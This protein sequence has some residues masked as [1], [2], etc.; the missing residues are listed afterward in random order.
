MQIKNNL[1]HTKLYD[2]RDMF[3][4]TMNN[5]PN[6]SGN[7]HNLRSHNIIISQLY[8]YSKVCQNK[9]DFTQRSSI[10]INTLQNQFFQTKI[11]K[12]KC[13]MFYN[14]YYHMIDKYSLSRKQFLRD[15][16]KKY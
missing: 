1:I 4:F 14:K 16:F 10:L 2:K 6:L 8:R 12:D 15:I 7:I 9:L 3:K 13:S 5:F 11:L